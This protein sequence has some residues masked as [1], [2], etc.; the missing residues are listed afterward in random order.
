[1]F[2]STYGCKDEAKT[3]RDEMFRLANGMNE[4]ASVIHCYADKDNDFM[5][6]AWYPGTYVKQDFAIFLDNFNDDI[7]KMF[8]NLSALASLL[9]K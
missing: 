4:L 2:T 3:K 1:M 8:L 9:L 6:E 5:I 7:S